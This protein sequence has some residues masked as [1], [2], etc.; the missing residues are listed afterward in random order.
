MRLGAEQL[1]ATF[2]LTR[3]YFTAKSSMSD[4][5][6]VADTITPTTP[7]RVEEVV[8]VNVSA[9]HLEGEQVKGEVARSQVTLHDSDTATHR[10]SSKPSNGSSVNVDSVKPDSSV[11]A[12]PIRTVVPV[13]S[14][15]IDQSASREVLPVDTISYPVEIDTVSVAVDT[16][17]VADTKVM[18][19]YSLEGQK[20]GIPLP[21]KLD[22][23]DGIFAL[24]LVCFL[25]LAHVYNGGVSFFK[26]NIL[27]VFS[28]SKSEKLE[29]QTTTKEIFYSYFLVFLAVLLI[30]ISLYEALDRFMPLAEGEKRPFATIGMFIVLILFFIIV[31]MMF[32]RLVGYIFDFD[33]RLNTWNRSY[34]V[35]LSMLGLLCFLP[36]L[37]LVYSSLWHSIIIGFV[38]IL[39]LIVQV[40]LF[41]RI[42]V[43]F[44]GQRFNFLY[45]IAY[46]CTIEILPYI[47]LG[48]G[49]VYLYRIDI[50]NT[51]I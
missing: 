31:K 48:I 26:E 28:A 43:F 41:L 35:L 18:S 38:L 49:L 40:I 3:D 30:S 19:T 5:N 33:K 36:T 10:V 29:N 50:F 17:A 16:I 32:N 37:M 4:L 6:I 44:I 46:L 11:V 22:R 51:I 9:G 39:F 47:F 2:R 25:L 14:S 15:D 1:L 23:S 34:Q 20:E 24:L 7:K 8:P 27:L 45:L 12:L 13:V 21:V 42:I